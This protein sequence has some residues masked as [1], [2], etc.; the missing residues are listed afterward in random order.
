MTMRFIRCASKGLGFAKVGAPMAL[1][2]AGLIAAD[3]YQNAETRDE[4]A[5]G[6]GNA[7][8]TLA[9]T[10]AGAAAGAAIG[11]VVP[12]IGTVVGGLIGGFLGSW[13]G[14][15]LG[16][17][18][19]KAAFGGPDAPAERLVLPDQP[20]PLRLPPPGAAVMPLLSQMAPSLSPGPLMLKAPAAPGPALGDVSRSLAAA[21]TATTA[22]AVLAAG[23]AA[24]PEPTRVDQQW[25]FSPTMPVTVQGDV[26]D[27]RQLA[28][29]LMPHMRQMFEEFSREQARRN[30]FDAPHV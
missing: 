29:E 1:I 11:S 8:G 19:G 18:V 12:V 27:P 5:E 10:L 21:P 16:G 4:K 30:L 17:A 23:L 24:K 2:E 14:G 7:A 25:T 6:Y 15:E 20:S 3:T 22:P 26:K 9:G 28:Q 13:G